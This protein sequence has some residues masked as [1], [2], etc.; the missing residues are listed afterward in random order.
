MLLHILQVQLDFLLHNDSDV[1]LLRILSFLHQ[2]I[3][4]AELNAGRVSD[5]RT[6]IQHMYLRRCPVVHIMPHFRPWPYQRHIAN[7]HIDEL[8][9]FIKFELTDKVPRASH[10]RVM[11][12]NSYQTTFVSPYPHGAE[13]KDLKILIIPTNT[14]LAIK[15]GAFAVQ[16]YPD[17][18]DK[19]KWTQDNQ[20]QSARYDIK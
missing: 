12:T 3:L 10:T 13:F 18:K 5:T 7:E 11:T 1:I 8:R 17:S 4:I 14:N 15:Y 2:F 9:Q 6:Y 16:F 20:S 19:K